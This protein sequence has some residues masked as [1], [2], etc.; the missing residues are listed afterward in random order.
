MSECVLMKVV[1][2]CIFNRSNPI[3]LGVEV[4]HGIASVGMHVSSKASTGDVQVGRI[5]A[6]EIDT[7]SEQVAYAGQKATV[8]IDSNVHFDDLTNEMLTGS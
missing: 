6:L 2:T 1:P 3:V 7:K 8:I 4:I 5:T